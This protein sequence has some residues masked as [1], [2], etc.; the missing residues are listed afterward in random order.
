[1]TPTAFFHYPIS[2][3]AA[4]PY[5]GDYPP[6]C[7][8]LRRQYSISVNISP[9]PGQNYAGARFFVWLHYIQ[10]KLEIKFASIGKWYHFRKNGSLAVKTR[11]PPAPCFSLAGK[12]PEPSFLGNPK[13]FESGGEKL[14]FTARKKVGNLTVFKR[15]NNRGIN[16][17]PISRKG[18]GYENRASVRQPQK[19]V[20]RKP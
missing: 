6:V 4:K 15:S 3:T 20:P 13:P 1:M 16:I 5:T 14:F 9:R 19:S 2:P 11:R 8:G 18:D 7:T 12:C 17:P 10:E